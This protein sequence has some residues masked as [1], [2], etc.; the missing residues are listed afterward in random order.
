MTTIFAAEALLPD[1]WAG[2]VRISIEG[3]RIV[4]IEHGVVPD[5]HDERH[6]I[7]LPGIAN[8][9]S[10]AFQRGMAGL[11]ERRGASS[12]SFWSWR[13]VMYRFALTMTPDEVEAVAAQLY[14]EMLE[15]GFCRVGEFHYLHHDRD[16]K[17]YANIAETAERIAA[18][19][20]ATGISLTLLPVFYAHSGFG[21][22]APN[23][24]QRRFIND[25]ARFASL[26]E[27]SRRAVAP[28]DGAVVGV[29]PHSLRAV[30][31]DELT[32]VVAL[33]GKAPIHIHVAEQEKEVED[34]I[35]WSRARPVEWLLANAPTGRRWCLV[36]ATHMTE[37]E[38]DA[39]ARRGAVA[40]LCPITEANL[41]DGTFAARRFLSAGGRFGIGS[42]SNVLIGVADEL[43]QLEYSQRL[44]RRERNVLGLANSS[45]GRHLFDEALNGGAAALGSGAAGIAAG[46]SADLV[47]LDAGHP[48]LAGKEGD[49]ILDTWIFAN[50]GKVDCVWAR[51]R[52]LVEGGRHALRDPIAA[53]YRAAI[54]KLAEA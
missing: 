7:V 51:G 30:T 46:R 49:A 6:A 3:G 48:T 33:A 10:H 50:G 44:K 9:H 23:E 37:A 41:G 22:V 28:L 12:D 32:E 16:G 39:L 26:L 53:A 47:T 8:L 20:A 17:P 14:V 25:P 11:T 27:E 18:A 2:N 35:A 52:K 5:A 21:G 29:A 15:A 24:G 42:D 31:P 36:H 13:E 4:G 34:C 40:G 43:R 19:A 1:G 54:A 38:T 45:T